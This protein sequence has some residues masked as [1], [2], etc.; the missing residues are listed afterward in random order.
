MSRCLPRVA[1][2]CARAPLPR[3]FCWRAAPSSGRGRH[4]HLGMTSSPKERG[5]N[6]IMMIVGCI[7]SSVTL[8][9]CLEPL[10]LPTWC[11]VSFPGPKSI[12]EAEKSFIFSSKPTR[13]VSTMVVRAETPH[14]APVGGS[15]GH[16]GVCAGEICALFL[17]IPA[18]L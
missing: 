16:P 1:E 2:S 6:P 10:H 17:N 5:Q 7:A 14:P 4:L 18:Q 11:H 12:V 8:I 13:Q 9:K 3:V 15:R